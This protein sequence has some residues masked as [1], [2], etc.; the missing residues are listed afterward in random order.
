[1][2]RNNDED[3]YAD[4][5]FGGSGEYKSGN[6]AGKEPKQPVRNDGGYDIPGDD[7]EDY[8]DDGF[9]EGADDEDVQEFKRTAQQFSEKLKELSE[10]QNRLNQLQ[11]QKAGAEKGADASLGLKQSD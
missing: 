8:E 7:D 3:D 2:Q 1:M 11:A 5:F 6:R 4:D 10:S 9:D